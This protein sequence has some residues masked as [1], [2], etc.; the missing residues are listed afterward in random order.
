[1]ALPYSLAVGQMEHFG[2][3]S[4]HHHHHHLHY[5]QTPVPPPDICITTTVKPD[6][7]ITITVLPH[8]CT[9]TITTTGHLHHYHH[10]QIPA[11]QH[12][13]TTSNTYC[14]C[15][16]V[17]SPVPPRLPPAYRGDPRTIY[18]RLFS[19]INLFRAASGLICQSYPGWEMNGGW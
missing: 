17:L 9:T 16:A 1:M 6:T 8:T 7:C 3:L 15:R 18:S 12:T 11:P 2:P 5:H 19:F 4:H 14:W 13:C 10:H